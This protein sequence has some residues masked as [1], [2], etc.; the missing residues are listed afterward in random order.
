MKI[1]RLF[2]KEQIPEWSQIFW[3]ALNAKTVVI[4]LQSIE[5]KILRF[6]TFYL[7]T[8]DM[9]GLELEK[10]IFRKTDAQKVNT[11]LKGKILI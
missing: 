4:E 6:N 9:P 3:G 2:R 5:E 10:S 8:I 1:N 7:D 11:H